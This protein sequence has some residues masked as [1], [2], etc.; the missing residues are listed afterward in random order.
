MKL[1]KLLKDNRRQFS[2]LNGLFF[3]NPLLVLGMCL[4]PVAVA[5]TSLQ[6]AVAFILM[7]TVM[8]FPTCAILSLIGKKVPPLFRVVLSPVLASIWY[9]PAYLLVQAL[10]P[11][12]LDRFGLF[13]PLMVIDLFFMARCANFAPKT[14]LGWTLLDTLCCC[15][16]V[17]VPI[18]LI[19][20]I[21]EVIGFG[22]IWEIS[23]GY[24]AT[25]SAVLLPFSGFF[26]VALLGAC[27]RFFSRHLRSGLNHYIEYHQLEEEWKHE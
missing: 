25:V 22:T 8:S 20:L 1:W 6:N 4:S 9:I 7:L 10:I 23:V 2:Y 16:G 18:C 5:I 14:K 13:L 19:G 15:I 26:L 27:L 17:A 11:Q 3:K 24:V 12:T 21:R